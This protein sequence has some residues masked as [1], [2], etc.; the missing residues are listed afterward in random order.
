MYTVYG[1]GQP[2]L[3]LT[4]TLKPDLKHVGQLKCTHSNLMNHHGWVI[5][6][7]CIIFNTYFTVL[8]VSNDDMNHPCKSP[9]ISTAYA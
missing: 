3:Y 8:N 7:I 9:C 1:S 5:R 4:T 6:R 2:Y